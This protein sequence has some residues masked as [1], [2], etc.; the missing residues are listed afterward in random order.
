MAV[1]NIIPIFYFMLMICSLLTK[2]LKITWPCWRVSTRLNP[3][4]LD[5]PRSTLEP[6]LVKYYMA[7][8]PMLG[9]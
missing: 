7:M 5:S 3:L 1:M 8:V 4:V 6:M 2:T 9:P